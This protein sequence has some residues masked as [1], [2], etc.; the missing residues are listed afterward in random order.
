[1]DQVPKLYFFN[2]KT[3]W[4]PEINIIFIFLDLLFLITND[5]Q[6]KVRL[7]TSV[8]RYFEKFN[9]LFEDLIQ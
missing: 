8:N 4:W 7:L 3:R 5:I 9:D 2:L 1:M 6:F